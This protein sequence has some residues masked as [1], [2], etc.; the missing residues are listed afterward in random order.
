METIYSR[1]INSSSSTQIALLIDP[2]ECTQESAKERIE[3]ANEVGVEFIFLGGSLV[4]H[5][6]LEDC[7]DWI[8][9]NTDIPLVLFPGNDSH[10]SPKA[11]AVLLLSLISG[12]NADLLIGKHVQSAPIIRQFKLEPISTAYMLIESGPLTSVQYMS[13]TMPIPRSKN[14]IAV[15]TAMAGEMIGMKAVYLDAGSGAE[16]AVPSSMIRDIRKNVDLPL[17]VGGGIRDIETAKRVAEAGANILVFGNIAEKDPAHFKEII[18][19]LKQ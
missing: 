14:N 18:Q 19:S 3:I 4:T 6:H 15:S 7:I 16:K 9:C 11:D 13:N 5:S 2:D 10:I 1:F 12:R 17:I 8:K